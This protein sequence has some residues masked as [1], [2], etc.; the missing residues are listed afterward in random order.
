MNSICCDPLHT[1]HTTHT[2]ADQT[3]TNT[4]AEGQKSAYDRLKSDSDTS[5]S[6]LP[7]QIHL[8]MNE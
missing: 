7:T 5:W 6:Q 4:G 2:E 3:M 1:Q 8:A